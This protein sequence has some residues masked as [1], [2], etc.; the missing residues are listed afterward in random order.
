MEFLLTDHYEILQTI[1]VNLRN[2]KKKQER[3]IVKAMSAATY[4]LAAC[5]AT[6]KITSEQY[7]SE[8]K[9]LNA[10]KN[11][12]LLRNFYWKYLELAGEGTQE[13]DKSR[14]NIQKE[15]KNKE[16]SRNS[17]WVL[18][19]SLQSFGLILGIIVI[20]LREKKSL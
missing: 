4:A 18:C 2:T 15:I 7:E 17:T 11:F 16:A 9:K 14:E 8:F 5:Q 10:L 19:F 20:G 6:K 1:Q 3:I 12:K 13:I